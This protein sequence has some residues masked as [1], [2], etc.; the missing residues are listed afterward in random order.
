MDTAKKTRPP[1]NDGKRPAAENPFTRAR[2]ALVAG[3][4]AAS[5]I[6]GCS[7][8]PPPPPRVDVYADHFEYLGDSYR[9]ASALAVALEAANRQPTV[10]EV[11][12]CSALSKLEPAL[13]VIRA[14]G[15]LK[16]R[17]SLPKN[18]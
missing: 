11:H 13:K 2:L 3:G 8:P 16:A 5:L 9:T 18:C 4:L 17:V 14:H 7:A 10:V 1:D 12:A 15:P 6:A